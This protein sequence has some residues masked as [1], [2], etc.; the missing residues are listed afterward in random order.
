MTTVADQKLVIFDVD[1]TLTR[2]R[3]IWQYLMEH[4]NCWTDQGEHN[5]A[6]FLN[7]EIDYVEF[8]R[9]DAQL[10]KGQR[11]DDL[12]RA[13][14]TIPMHDGL[15][16][17]F[18]YFTERHF[19]IGLVST[20]LKLLTD[21][22][23]ARYPVDYCVVNDL[24]CDGESCSGDAI[25][26]LNDHEKDLAVRQIIAE[27]GA[28]YVVAFGDSRGDI[29]VFRLANFSVS[30]NSSDPELLRLAT[31]QHT[32]PDLSACLDKLPF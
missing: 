21:H 12:K 11:Y 20:G 27:C 10:L 14:F 19:K 15:D 5:L 8:C 3:S 18:A 16:Q 6:K 13:A 32:G 1:G 17:V 23:T 28:E 29:P 26:N 2:R 25:I 22:F 4:T 9:L 24:A 31:Y 30:V 7:N